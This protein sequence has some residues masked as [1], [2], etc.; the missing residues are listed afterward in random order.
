MT[1]FP[2]FLAFSIAALTGCGTAFNPAEARASTNVPVAAEVRPLHI[3]YDP[4]VPRFVIQVQPVSFRVA[5]VAGTTVV[6]GKVQ[7]IELDVKT[8]S[9]YGDVIS[10]QLESALSNVENFVLYDASAKNIPVNKGERGPFVVSA[11]ITEFSETADA[12][13]SGTGG[14]LG[15]AGL[16]AGIAGAVTDKPGLMWGGAAVAAANPT[17]VDAKAKR[18]GVVGM[19]IKILEKKTGRIIRSFPVRGTFT[20]VTHVNGFSIFG[21]G[22]QN[23]RMA[24]SALGQALRVALN[25]A[26]AETFETLARRG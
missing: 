26:A 20:A 22:K 18:T 5:S 4:S 6:D 23:Q 25:D 24:Q 15:T 9:E 16:I 19:D 14:S 10:A 1:I 13:S 17:F 21:I 12:E 7:N 8:V 2:V 3:P 11:T